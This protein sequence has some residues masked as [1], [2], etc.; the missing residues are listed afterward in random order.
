MDPLFNPYAPGAG[1]QPPELAG[2]D[3]L[4]EKAIL[5]L[6][7]LALGRFGR[8]LVLTGLRGV[9]KTVLLN[10]IRQDAEAVQMVTV[11]V[12]FR[13]IARCLLCWHQA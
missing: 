6:R 9:G 4:L 13:K 3:E 5:A 2:R 1:A 10:R 11:R 7:R 8:S 12:E